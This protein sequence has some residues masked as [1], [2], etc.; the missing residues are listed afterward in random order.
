M[1]IPPFHHVTPLLASNQV[2]NLLPCTQ[3]KRYFGDLLSLHLRRSYMVSMRTQRT[4][5]KRRPAAAAAVD[6]GNGSADS[7]WV[8][9]LKFLN[10][11]A[12]IIKNT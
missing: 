5:H 10:V 8:Y 12:K 11:K 7:V 1:K 6:G 9:N 2:Y 4:T 3:I